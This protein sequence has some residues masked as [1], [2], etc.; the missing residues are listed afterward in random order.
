MLLSCPRSLFRDSLYHSESHDS[1]AAFWLLC[2]CSRCFRNLQPAI[3]ARASVC[4]PHNSS[5]IGER[6]PHASAVARP[7]VL[8]KSIWTAANRRVTAAMRHAVA[9]GSWM[10][11]GL[12]DGVR[13][14]RGG[15]AC[16][17]RGT[18]DECRGR[19]RAH[20]AELSL[21]AASVFIRSRSHASSAFP[22]IAS[23]R[24]NGVHRSPLGAAL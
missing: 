22:P 15:L 8:L 16:N 19:S 21:V 11:E 17:I 13:E 9:A 14:H 7:S 3:S 1:S 6:R 10:R 20:L 18:H 24:L 2:L 12:G 5:R 4:E 23:K